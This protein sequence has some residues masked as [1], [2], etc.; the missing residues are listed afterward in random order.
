MPRHRCWILLLAALVGC[1]A[2]QEP[3]RW[4]LSPEADAQRVARFTDSD[5]QHKTERLFIEPDLN[6]DNYLSLRASGGRAVPFLIRALDDPRAWTA[7]FATP[8]YKLTANSPFQRIC[9]LLCSA[10]GIGAAK[11]VARY[12]KHPDSRFRQHAARLLGILGTADCLEPLKVAL[13][14]PERH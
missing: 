10:D 12:L 1:R 13:A 6:N 5:L 9:D 3:Y 14:D 8:G 11:P 2:R 4:G 7:V